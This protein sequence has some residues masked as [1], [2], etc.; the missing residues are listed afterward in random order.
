MI[1]VGCSP[2]AV[3][4]GGSRLWRRPTRRSVF[5]A[6]FGVRRVDGPARIGVWAPLRRV[7]RRDRVG[8]AR[9]PGASGARSPA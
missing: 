1:R 8:E 2:G 7:G 3:D 4:G 9:P 6:R 5:E